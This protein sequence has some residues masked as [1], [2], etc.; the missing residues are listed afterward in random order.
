MPAKAK[1]QDREAGLDVVRSYGLDGLPILFVEVPVTG[2]H[3]DQI[4]QIR[5]VEL[6]LEAEQALL[7]QSE[8]TGEVADD[9]FSFVRFQIKQG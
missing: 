4:A 8:T 1:G 3:G 6:H 5:R 9:V 2:C 7:Q